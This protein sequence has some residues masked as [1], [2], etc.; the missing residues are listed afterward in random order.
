MSNVLDNLLRTNF[1]PHGHCY[2]WNPEILWLNVISDLL[3]ATAYFSIPIAIFYFV[4]QRSDLKF[5]GIFILFSLFIALCG[6]THLISIF[7][8]WHGAYGLHG[9]AKLVT[10]IVSC[11]TAYKVYSSIPAALQLPNV[12]QL[13]KAM[14]DASNARLENLRLENEHQ[15][16][17]ILRE[18]TDSAHVGIMVLASDGIITVANKTTCSIF[19]YE[20]DELENRHINLLVATEFTEKHDQLMQQFINGIASDAA[21]NMNRIV[22][23]YKKDGSPVPLEIR[24]NRAQHDVHTVYVSVQDI[25][26]RLNNEQALAASRSTTDSLIEH[27]PLGVHFYQYQQNKFSLLKSN[28]I[29]DGL[30][31][32][33]ESDV[34]VSHPALTA[35]MQSVAEGHEKAIKTEITL[36]VPGLQSLQLYLFPTS[37]GKLVA[38]FEDVT[39][40]KQFQGQLIESESITR[41]A[42]NASIAGVYIFDVKN[43]KNQFVNDRYTAITGYSLE[44]L[45][46]LNGG[47]SSLIHPEDLGKVKHHFHHLLSDPTDG[48]VY[49]LQ[50]R[51]K[52][53]NGNWLWLMAQDVVFDRNDKGRPLKIM[54]SFLDITPLKKMQDNLLSLKDRAEDANQSKSEFLANMSHEIRT[55][56]NAVIALTDMV[57]KMEMGNKQREYLKKVQASSRSLLQILNDILDY[58]KLEA[59]KLEIDNTP[60]DLYKMLSNSL[61]LF[62]TTAT[63][64]NLFIDSDVGKSVPRFVVGD[65]TRIAQII[66]NLL[67]NAIKFTE[68]GEVTLSVTA[69]LSPVSGTYMVKFAVSDTGIGI[70]KEKLESL[71]TSFSQADSSIGRRFG[72][73]GLG[74]S[75]C[76]HLA[77]LLNGSLTVRSTPGEGSTFTLSLPLIADA[78][79]AT[80]LEGKLLNARTLI[81][82][83]SSRHIPV[84]EQYFTSVGCEVSIVDNYNYLHQKWDTDFDVVMIDMTTLNNAEKGSVMEALLSNQHDNMITKGVIFLS[85]ESHFHEKASDIILSTASAWLVTPFV[86]SDLEESVT[87]ILNRNHTL[88]D[89]TK[90]KPP[91]MF[92]GASVLLV[93]D[94]PTN[95]FVATELLNAVGLEVVVAEDGVE[96]ISKFQKKPFDI[97]LMDLQMPNMDGFTAARKI[98]NLPVGKTIPI[99]AMSAAVMESDKE[100]VVSTGMDGHIAKPVVR[101]DL[102]NLLERVLVKKIAR[103]D[104]VVRLPRDQQDQ[105]DAAIRKALATTLIG[106]DIDAATGRLGNDVVTYLGLLE[107]FHLHFAKFDEE[108]GEHGDDEK[109]GRRLH[110]MK[111]LSMSIGATRLETLVKEAEHL[112]K[113]GKL[114]STRDLRKEFNIVYNNTGKA[115]KACK[116]FIEPDVGEAKAGL[117]ELILAVKNHQYLRKSDVEPHR[118][119][120]EEK[121]GKAGSDA[122]ITAIINL[123]Y[124]EAM[125]LLVTEEGQ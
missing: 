16:D 38:M 10:A 23:G 2:L 90:E 104:S 51:V 106:F 117:D 111:G 105:D 66:N 120:L 94:H 21:L 52:H 67:G 80:T 32:K 15:Q 7:V 30:L 24:L 54:G 43:R 88:K 122:I 101:E 112:H 37:P 72:G 95:Q 33:C 44:Q 78:H 36:P 116:P 102:Y 115:L 113:S 69:E 79:H 34:F 22:T 84:I 42:I 9:I 107:N 27:M 35:K 39:E 124:K 91:L 46:N 68:K 71:F 1:M 85:S 8:I 121:Y 4:R 62:S 70:D 17:L 57:L 89:R 55:P 63:Q 77:T 118:N 14:E 75:I 103:A 53:V 83:N 82:G 74:L 20:K 47:I 100:K 93:E 50:Y 65:A 41:R 18:S 48:N 99:Y 110:T 59:G 5:K 45:N 87:A 29:A 26:E 96:A 86:L 13:K 114:Q 25:S 108:L 123:D 58:S 31:S 61:H 119:T 109:I 92:S 28:T 64:K 60:F 40:A 81:I 125:S 97:V 98:R 3:I 6:V 12:N 19:G 76:K 73:T 56:M 49:T 11:I